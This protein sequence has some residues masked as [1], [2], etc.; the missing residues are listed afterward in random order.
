VAWS[1]VASSSY[2]NQSKAADTDPIVFGLGGATDPAVGDLVVAALA[3]DNITTTDTT[4]GSDCLS[5]SWNSHTWT[6]LC[7][8]TNGQGAAEA[9]ASLAVFWTIATSATGW[10][11]TNATF[12][13]S[14]T[15]RAKAFSSSIFRTTGTISTGGGIT[16]LATDGADLASMSHTPGGNKEYLFIRLVAWEG[17]LFNDTPAPTDGTWTGLMFVT[18]SGGGA[19]SN[20]GI[21][22]EAKI[23]T[24]TTATSDPSAASGRDHV[25]A[26]FAFEYAEAAAHIPSIFIAKQAVSRAAHF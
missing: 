2:G 25:N 21:W 16:S 20:M 3:F 12:E 7:E 17:N 6:K 13:M 26:M 24:G 10:G 11:A 8:V 18:T 1:I 5:L 4:L 23:V 19:T 9:G 22:G 14:S 15:V